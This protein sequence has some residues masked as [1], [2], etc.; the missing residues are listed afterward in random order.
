MYELDPYLPTKSRFWKLRKN[1]R[2]RLREDAKPVQGPWRQPLARIGNRE[3]LVLAEHAMDERRG[4][5]FGYTLASYDAE[6]FVPVYAAQSGEV[7]LAHETPAGFAVSIDH[8]GWTWSTHYAHLSKMFVTRQLGQ[9]ERRH[10]R[11]HVRAGEVIGYAAKSPAHIRF[12]LWQWTNDR[13][14]VAVDPIPHLSTWQPAV[15]PSELRSVLPSTA[16]QDAA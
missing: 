6:L 16:N 5:D 7:S 8:G 4:V 3:P 14:F 11:Q 12:E 10:R 2:F 15:E 13:G 1:S 9:P